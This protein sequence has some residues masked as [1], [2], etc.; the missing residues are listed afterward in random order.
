MLTESIREALETIDER[1]VVRAKVKGKSKEVRISQIQVE[2]AL[3]LHKLIEA[4]HQ[5]VYDQLSRLN[6][7]VKSPSTETEAL[8]DIGY[9]L[10]EL[11]N[12]FDEQRKDCKSLKELASKTIGFRVAQDSLTN[13]DADPCVK[14]NFARATADVKIRPKMPAKGSPAY[15]AALDFF[16]VP[17]KAIADGVLK[18]DWKGASDYLTTKMENG[19]K[20]PEGLN[21]TYTEVTCTFTRVTVKQESEQSV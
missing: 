9:F 2:R 18:V 7:V 21:E 11:E 15:M 20:L 4:V 12:I 6:A 10:R 5:L 3:D 19:E 13:P 1:D 8:V 16:Y 14:G 17:R